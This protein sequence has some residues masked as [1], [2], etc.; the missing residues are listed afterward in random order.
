MAFTQQLVTFSLALNRDAQDLVT[1]F[2]AVFSAAD[3]NVIQ[4]MDHSRLQSTSGAGD[5]HLRVAYGVSTITGMR[6]EARL[7]AS[8]ATQTAQDAFDADFQGG[9]CAVPLFMLDLSDHENS[10]SSRTQLFVVFAVTN[11]GLAIGNGL[12]GHQDAIF[13]AEPLGNIAVGATGN[14]TLYDA[15]GAPVA[16]AIPVKNVGANVWNAGERA[17]TI[18][19]LDE[20]GYIAIAT[21]CGAAA[22]TTTDTTTTAP[23]VPCITRELVSQQPK[24]PNLNAWA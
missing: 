23:P 14:A 3:V 11:R 22:L 17:M 5:L 12:V 10:I 20:G 1:A 16:S 24:S 13:A 7:Y 15:F 4:A 8:S 9:F 2:N 19:D 18:Y 21:C 6:Y